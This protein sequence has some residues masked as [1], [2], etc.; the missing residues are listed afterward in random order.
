MKL[1]ADA[2][3]SKNNSLVIVAFKPL[4]YD[5]KMKKPKESASKAVSE[6]K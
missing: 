1:V 3:R 2:R 4:F 5:F 6:C